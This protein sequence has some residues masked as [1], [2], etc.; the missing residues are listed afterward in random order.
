MHPS[1]DE[2]YLPGEITDE[3]AEIGGEFVDS[4]YI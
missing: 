4:T 2:E 3:G 1:V